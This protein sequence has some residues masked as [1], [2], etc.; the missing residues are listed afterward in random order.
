LIFKNKLVDVRLFNK[1]EVC[2]KIGIPPIMLTVEGL[3]T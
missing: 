1:K 2:T 3:K